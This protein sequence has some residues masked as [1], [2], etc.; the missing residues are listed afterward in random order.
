VHRLMWRVVVCVGLFRVALAGAP[1]EATVQGL[2]EGACKDAKGEHKIEARLVA[3][4]NKSYKLYVRQEL[5]DGK[6]CKVVLDGATGADA[7]T[8]AGKVGNVEW[9]AAYAEGTLKGTCGEGC[10]LELTRVGRQPPTLGAKPPEGAIALLPPDPKSGD[11]MTRRK[12]KDGTEPDWTLSEDGGIRVPKGGMS[13]KRQFGGSFRLH[14]EFKC[15]LMPAGR[16]Q[17]RGNS[18]VYLPN[19]DEIQVLDSFG[20][21]TYLGGGCGGIYKYKD[22]DTMEE[23]PLA[24]GKPPLRFNLASLP[25][26]E[27][28]TYD[29][30]YLAVGYKGPLLGGL[31]FRLVAAANSAASREWKDSGKAPGYTE[32]AVETRR[33]DGVATEKILVSDKAETGGEHVQSA[34]AVRPHGGIGSCVSVKLTSEGEQRFGRLTGDHVGERLAIV[35]NTRRDARGAIVEK[36]V[37]YSAPRIM[38]RILGDAVIHGDFDEKGASALAGALV[39]QA[40]AL[41]EGLAR[42]R[43]TVYHNGIKIHDDFELKGTARRTFHFQDHGCPVQYRNIWMLPV[44]GK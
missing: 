26:G 43:V 36:G 10:A 7:V 8:F 15:P 32:Y 41:R 24:P 3:Q 22:P 42:P 23:L 30:T 44:E 14:V 33:D 4:G 27:W 9:S 38:T 17:G 39:V 6:L 18:G 35:H 28:Q 13:S 21:D 37:C 5:G 16:G 12:G 1:D 2:Y 40:K 31:E 34:S 29:V 11:E 20:M 19:G 25:P